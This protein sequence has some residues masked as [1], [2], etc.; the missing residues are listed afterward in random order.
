V[1]GEGGGREG[2]HPS[3]INHEFIDTICW[4]IGQKDKK[5]QPMKKQGNRSIEEREG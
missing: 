5:E 3:A 1:E 4:K 2:E